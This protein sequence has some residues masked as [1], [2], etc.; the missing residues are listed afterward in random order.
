LGQGSFGIVYKVSKR[1][2]L[3]EKGMWRNSP[4][5]IKMCQSMFSEQVDEFIREA[6]LTV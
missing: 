3:N 5:A 2:R 1:K 4:V 6:Q